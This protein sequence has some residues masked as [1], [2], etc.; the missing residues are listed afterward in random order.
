[1]RDGV[2]VFVVSCCFPFAIVCLGPNGKKRAN[3]L[4]F[5]L[6]PKDPNRLI[7]EFFYVGCRLV[8]TNDMKISVTL[9]NSVHVC[10]WFKDN[11]RAI[12]M[13]G[14]SKTGSWLVACHY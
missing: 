9:P 6:L 11:V 7:V 5:A 14:S 10:G 3:F 2:A 12:L 1:M 13:Q 8:A 4:L